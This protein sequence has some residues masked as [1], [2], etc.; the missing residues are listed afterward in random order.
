MESVF[1]QK[2][3]DEN[4]EIVDCLKE[5]RLFSHLNNDYITQLAPVSELED[6]EPGDKILVE[7][8]PNHKVNF[9]LR[10]IVGIYAGNELILKLQRRGDIFGEMSIISDKPCSAS[11]IAETRVKVFT[12]HS[13]FIGGYTNV[14]KESLDDV[15]YRMFAMIMTEKLSLTTHKA[16]KYEETNRLLTKTKEQLQTTFNDLQK[17]HEELKSTHI[18]LVQ[19]AKMVS[20]GEMA[21]GIAHEL[22][23]PLTI[24]NSL[25][26]LLKEDLKTLAPK[27]SLVDLEKIEGQVVRASVITNHLRNFGRKSSSDLQVHQLNAIIEE[28]FILINEQLRL[29]NITVNKELSRSLPDI[30]CN[31]NQLEQVL[32]N[33]IV[34]ARDAMERSERKELTV[35]SFMKNS[36]IVIEIEDTGT[37]IPEEI[38]YKIF[39]PFFTTK[40]VGQGMGLGLSIS[41]QIIKHHQGKISVK[42]KLNK[43]TTF[44]IELPT[45]DY[46]I[47]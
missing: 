36:T 3:F 7:G 19:S 38:R 46:S 29:K 35:R 15:L 25:V 14:D 32:T 10:G 5:F 18:Q 16:K 44:R 6:Y 37:G 4:Q 11:V 33:I 13:K 27:Q 26:E 21:A 43:G 34:N 28:S 22:N 45:L 41:Y 1:D 2:L 23:Q 17:A 47:G 9:L 39:D 12:I 20:L 24:I 42:S 30:T 31:K 40:D 8:E